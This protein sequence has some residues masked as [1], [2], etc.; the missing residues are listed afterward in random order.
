VGASSADRTIE[1]QGVAYQYRFDGSQW[2]RHQEVRS[3][4]PGRNWAF[5]S[6]IAFD[7]QKLLVA[8][9]GGLAVHVFERSL[10]GPWTHAAR[11]RA[12]TP[13]APVQFGFALALQGTDLL[14]GAPDEVDFGGWPPYGAAYLFDLACDDCTPDLDADGAL[15]VFDYLTF[16]NLFDAGS[17]E[18]DF[19]GDGELTVLDFLAYQTA[20]DAGCA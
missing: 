19:D 9:R 5:G 20:F 14:V 16:L 18:A 3:S 1:N 6:N 13:G 2:Q 12:E 15:T 7:G 8:E 11:L 10:A 17:S 4:Q